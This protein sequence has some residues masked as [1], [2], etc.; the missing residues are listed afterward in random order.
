MT[1]LI[2][3]FSN[4]T[5]APTQSCLAFELNLFRPLSIQL[6]EELFQQKFIICSHY[7]RYY[8]YYYYYQFYYYYLPHVWGIG[9]ILRGF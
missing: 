2:L 8:Y 7:Y 9:E 5:K 3:A 4:F 1:K 6:P